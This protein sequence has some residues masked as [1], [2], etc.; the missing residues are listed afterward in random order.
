MTEPVD[1]S[2][3][4]INIQSRGHQ[5]NGVRS[6]NPI[7][8]VFGWTQSSHDTS[9]WVKNLESAS[10]ALELQETQ[11]GLT[12]YGPGAPRVPRDH[13]MTHTARLSD[14]GFQIDSCSCR[15]EH[16]SNCRSIDGWSDRARYIEPRPTS[17]IDLHSHSVLILVTVHMQIYLQIPDHGKQSCDNR[18]ICKELLN[19]PID[20]LHYVIID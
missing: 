9:H 16:W 19:D 14:R 11:T 13:R 12:Y 7:M 2:E 15:W 3:R 8:K 10:G 5:W 18:S 20:V 6:I 1:R 4:I 17:L